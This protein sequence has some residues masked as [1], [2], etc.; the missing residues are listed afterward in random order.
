M[1]KQSYYKWTDLPQTA[2]T[3]Q[4]ERRLV[5]GERVMV[6]ELTLAKGVIIGE[7]QHPHEQ[8][9]HLLSG[10]IEFDFRGEKRIM[11]SGEIVHIPSNVPHAV[12]ALED[13]VAFD[14]FSPPR[15]DFLTEE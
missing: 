14:I 12:V 15:E 5:T 10:K 11:V 8:L 2:V 7:H 3:P 4:I 13:S 1:A 9:T 6:V